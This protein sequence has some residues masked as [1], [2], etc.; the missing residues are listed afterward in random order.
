MDR[1]FVEATVFERNA[2]H[3]LAYPGSRLTTE[4]RSRRNFSLGRRKVPSA[5]DSISQLGGRIAC[6]DRLF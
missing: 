6:L 1:H 3:A 2:G 4:E 5:Y